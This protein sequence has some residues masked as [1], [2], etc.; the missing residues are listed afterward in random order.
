M[1]IAG[2]IAKIEE[3]IQ[4]A[5]VNAGRKRDE[6]T[7]MGVSKFEPVEKLEQAYRAGVRCF[8]E[9]RVKEAV[10]KL[11][12]FKTKQI[13]AQIHLIGSLQRNKA[14]Q[15]A[16]FFDCIQS[17]DREELITE[18]AKHSVSRSESL[19][20]LFELHTGEE[21][22]SGFAVNNVSDFDALF[23]AVDLVLNCKSLKP[24]GL[25][26]MAPFTED[27]S[28]IRASF[29]QLVKAQKELEK[30]FP[31]NDGNVNWT[32]LSMGMSNDYEIAI[33]EG[34]TLLRIGS[35]IFKE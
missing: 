13:E 33:E 14:K 1:S 9:S 19:S 34:S 17:L 26:T 5:C 18:L 10:D 30:R 32:V 25:M 24:A 3:R 8:G 35:A 27:T 12:G 2:N 7:L 23:K 6:I 29:R 20:V 21:S 28:L 16:L 4:K 15:A 22:K 31:S 11:T